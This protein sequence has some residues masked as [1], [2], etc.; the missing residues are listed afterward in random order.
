METE[1]RHHCRDDCVTGEH[2]SRTHR[3]RQNCE[4][5]VTIDDNAIRINRKATIGITVMRNP[6]NGIVFAYGRDQVAHVRTA[7]TIVDIETIW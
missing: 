7:A 1:I 6:D 5:L 3:E 2:T 4:N